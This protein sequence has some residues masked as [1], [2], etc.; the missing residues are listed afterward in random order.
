MHLA[1]ILKAKFLSIFQLMKINENDLFIKYVFN[2][3]QGRSNMPI[4]SVFLSI[5]NLVPATLLRKPRK[6]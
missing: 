3:F 2:T 4:T 6:K 1:N 5:R